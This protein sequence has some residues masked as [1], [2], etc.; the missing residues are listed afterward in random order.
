MELVSIIMPVYNTEMYVAESI[1]S[2]MAQTYKSI[3]LIIINDGSVD[4]SLRICEEYAIKHDNIHVFSKQNGGISSARNMGIEKAKGDYLVF[5]DSDD[6]LS[7]DMVELLMTSIKRNGSDIAV[8]DMTTNLK[9][10]GNGSYKEKVFSPEEAIKMILKETSF[11]TSAGAKLY[12]KSI[13]EDIRFP[14]GRIYEDYATVYLAF[15]KSQ[16]ISYINRIMYYYRVNMDSITHVS[17]SKKRMQYFDA[18]REIE[19]YITNKYP[20]LCKYLRIRDTRYAISFYK[21]MLDSGVEDAEIE[22]ALR[23]IVKDNIFQYL[24]S[25]YSIISKGY[26][27]CIVL[28]RKILKKLSKRQ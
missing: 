4:N 7:N 1:E 22:K 27:V 26:G 20:K 25:R 28:C 21:Q 3:E 15:G 9:K 16:K 14:I 18:S 12:V 10:V 8:C 2:V 13:F 24:F 17:F 23:R 5:L 6:I 19:S 11:S